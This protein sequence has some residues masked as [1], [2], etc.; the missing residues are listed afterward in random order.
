MLTLNRDWTGKT[1]DSAYRSKNAMILEWWIIT[2]YWN[3]FIH[4]WC[5]S[6]EKRVDGEAMFYELEWSGRKN[7]VKQNQSLN[8]HSYGIEGSFW[9]S[10]KMKEKDTN[11]CTYYH[12]PTLNSRFTQVWVSGYKHG[13]TSVPSPPKQA[14]SSVASVVSDMCVCQSLTPD[15]LCGRLPS[16]LLLVSLGLE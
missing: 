1:F 14:L 8:K 10:T 13:V 12:A 16:M 6:I 4:S 11:R 5:F 7:S 3:K 9:L 15:F 2:W